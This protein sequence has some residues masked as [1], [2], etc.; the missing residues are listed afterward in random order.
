[1]AAQSEIET[2]FNYCDSEAFFSSDERKQINTI[3]KLA[4]QHPKECVILRP[5]ETNGGFI[6][7]KVPASWLHV[8]PPRKVEMSEEQ[9]IAA[10][11]R[12]QK[13]REQRNR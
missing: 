9:R 10:T 13:A 6:Y 5:P 7:A 8:R 1:M 4:T 11:E 12:L 2:C 3:R